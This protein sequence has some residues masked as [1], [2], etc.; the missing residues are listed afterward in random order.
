[1]GG[2]IMETTPPRIIASNDRLGP[3]ILCMTISQGR[4][5][6]MVLTPSVGF[7]FDQVSLPH[8]AVCIVLRGGMLY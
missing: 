8:W 1:M 6:D 2:G 7:G 4:A 5:W 3:I